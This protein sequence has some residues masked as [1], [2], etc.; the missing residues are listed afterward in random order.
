MAFM[1]SDANPYYKIAKQDFLSYVEQM[2]NMENDFHPDMIDEYHLVKRKISNSAIELIKL[3][4]P[5]EKK[6]SDID[7]MV[8][9]AI[10]SVPLED[11][12]RE[13][14]EEQFLAIFSPEK[15][16][17]EP[18]ARENKEN[19]DGEHDPFADQS[20]E[21][22]AVNPVFTS[23][24]QAFQALNNYPIQ[25][26]IIQ[27]P[28]IMPTEKKD[29]F[30]E[31]LSDITD[32][33][34]RVILIEKEKTESEKSAN[35]LKDH[36]KRLQSDFDEKE[37]AHDEEKTQV[38]QH[39]EELIEKISDLEV[40]NSN[41]EDSITEIQLNLDECY[42]SLD[43]ERMKNEA[44]T[45]EKGELNQDILEKTGEI[46]RLKEQLMREH[47]DSVKK[48]AVYEMKVAEIES[49]K[50][51]T[52]KQINSLNESINRL[53]SEND[54]KTAQANEKKAQSDRTINELRNSVSKLEE[55]KAKL[56]KEL[57]EAKK[58]AENAKKDIETSTGEAEKL[59]ARVTELEKALE[60]A[61]IDAENIRKSS[62]KKS[63]TQEEYDAI[64][65]EKN[66][67]IKSKGDA[68]REKEAVLKE[69]EEI[70]EEKN[71]L[72]E[73]L[74]RK[75]KEIE[76]K[77]ARYTDM[78]NSID[79]LKTLAYV[80]KK[81]N[82]GNQNAFDRD[83]RL[84]EKDSHILSFVS[85][86]G[87]REIN[88]RF[89]KKSGDKTICE[90]ANQLKQAFGD[91]V[92]RVMGDQFLTIHKDS[93]VNSVQ[94]TLVDLRNQL[95]T[96]GI[97]IIYGVVAGSECE[98]LKDMLRTAENK[99]ES[100]K[101]SL[102]SEDASV[103]QNIQQHLVTPQDKKQTSSVQPVEISIDE[104]LLETLDDE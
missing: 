93:T 52:E 72:Q 42:N 43:D 41:L 63:K 30:T 86:S 104:E 18:E 97:K 91:R 23:L 5:F 70:L 77:E 48:L 19:T 80:D 39:T 66:N 60:A 87:M 37:K 51:R 3:G 64:V 79:E 9:D 47:D 89:N 35:E 21:D 90:V 46:E 75:I 49:Y 73:E 88:K 6:E 27:Q 83:F 65:R 15:E 31:L 29:S 85:I 100:M 95:G 45:F 20:V 26:E 34:R 24:M 32:I 61:K 74:N 62:E 7:L 78:E 71:R 36:C 38:T 57:S 84:I 22:P 12:R 58:E 8:E 33:Q 13:M 4:V 53:R 69:K 101:D 96:N 17:P 2:H 16:E 56:E 82:T 68:I 98:T 54:S 99:A 40:Q 94:G 11:I 81:T 67:L 10:Y 59:K 14:N 92:Y 28:I 44:L 25:K 50:E 76:D 1:Q 102:Q 103:Y 55:S